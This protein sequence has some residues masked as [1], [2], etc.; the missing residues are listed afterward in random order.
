MIQAKEVLQMR[1]GQYIS[2]GTAFKFFALLKGS[3]NLKM[4]GRWLLS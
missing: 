3:A 4:L 1:A 2:Q